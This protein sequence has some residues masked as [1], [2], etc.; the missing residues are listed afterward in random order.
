MEKL[1]L[2]DNSRGARESRGRLEQTQGSEVALRGDATALSCNQRSTPA[3][4]R[5]VSGLREKF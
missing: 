1:L 2:V 3:L 4:A 5:S